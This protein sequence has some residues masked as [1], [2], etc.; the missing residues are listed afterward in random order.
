MLGE[1]SPLSYVHVGQFLHISHTYILHTHILCT[2]VHVRSVC[3]SVRR[4][5]SCVNFQ[6]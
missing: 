3:V 1:A 2:Y 4:G 6:L 5:D